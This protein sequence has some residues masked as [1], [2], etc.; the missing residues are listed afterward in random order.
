MHIFGVGAQTAREQL[1]RVGNAH[2]DRNLY[3]KAATSLDTRNGE[4]C[5]ITLGVHSSRAKG[6]RR[7]AS[8]RL[9]AAPC[10]HAHYD[11]MYAILKTN[12]DARITTSRI[13]DIVYNGL[14]DFLLSAPN[15][16]YINVGNYMQI[17]YL[18]ECDHDNWVSA[19]GLV[20]A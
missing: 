17:A 15:T 3:V 1:I 19:I 18:C 20:N 11:V 12:P 10:W 8:G 2:Y 14:S 16:A 7:A 4:R 9:C 5:R 6:A 13:G